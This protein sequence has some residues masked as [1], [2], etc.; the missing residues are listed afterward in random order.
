MKDV[1]DTVEERRKVG[2]LDRRFGEPESV[3]Q[4]VLFEVAL[5]ERAGVIVRE[6]VHAD[7]RRPLVEEAGRQMRSDEARDTGDESLHAKASRT[8]SGRRQ[9]LPEASSAACTVFPSAA[10]AWSAFRTIWY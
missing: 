5:L 3:A 10:I 6:P 7:D 2:I 9:G 8:R 1:G 4:P